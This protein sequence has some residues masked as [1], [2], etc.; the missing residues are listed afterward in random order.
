MSAEKNKYL[1]SIIIPVFNTAEYLD[2]CLRSVLEQTDN[3][4]E[5]I[6]IDDGS[7]DS[8]GKI[9]SL[10]CKNNKKFKLITQSNSGLSSARN[11]GIDIS[12]GDFITFLDSDDYLGVNSI[13]ILRKNQIEYHSDIVSARFMII[14]EKGK[15]LEH[16]KNYIKDD[17]YLKNWGYLK[18]WQQV[19]GVFA[20]SIV[21]ARLIRKSLLLDYNIKFPITKLPHED[22]CFTYKVL[23]KSSKNSQI[24]NAI[25][26][27]R[28]RSNS[29]SK[30]ISP[31][32]LIATLYQLQ[33]AKIFLGT[34]CEC[35][36]QSLLIRRTFIT[37]INYFHTMKTSESSSFQFFYTYLNLHRFELNNFLYIAKKHA[38]IKA[39]IIEDLEGI[40]CEGNNYFEKEFK[41]IK[42]SIVIPIYNCEKFLDATLKSIKNQSLRDFECIMVDDLS[43]DS[44]IT[45][46][47]KYA[48]LDSRFKIVKHKVNSG[49]AASRNSGTRIAKGKYICFLD[50]DDLM[51]VDGLKI[52]CV[53]LEKTKDESV[54]GCYCGSITIQE[55]EK[56]VPKG[57][58]RPQLGNIDFIS[59]RGRCLFNAN[60]P[61]F[62][63]N[64]FIRMGGFNESLTQAEDYEL[65][66]RFL[67]NGYKVI[68]V[69]FDGV[70]YRARRNS[71]IRKGSLVHLHT[72]IELQKEYYLP[73]SKARKYSA[74]LFY[75]N[76]P[77][78]TYQCQKDLISRILP[79]VGMALASGN[80]I[81]E[82]S[83]EIAQS[84]PSVYLLELKNEKIYELL[85][86]GLRRFHV[87]E[88]APFFNRFKNDLNNL[89]IE[90]RTKSLIIMK[91][92]NNSDISNESSV[93]ES[94]F[95]FPV[96]QKKV[97]IVFFPHKDYHIWTIHL[98]LESL[99]EQGL[100][101][102]VVDN[103]THYRD[104]GNRAKAKELNIELLR[105]SNFILGDYE[106]KLLVAFNDWDPIVKSIFYSA[107]SAGVGTASIVE[108]IQDYHDVDTK[109][110]RHPYLSSELVILPGEFDRKYFNNK[111][112]N[113]VVGGVPRILDLINKGDVKKD[114]VI[115][116]KKIA[117]INTNF[118]YGVLVDKRDSWLRKSV[119]SALHCGYKV[120]ISRH[121]ADLGKTYQKFVSDKNF[122][123]LLE[124]S[125]VVIQ[126]FAS[127]ILEAVARNKKTIYFNPHNEKIDKFKDPLGAYWIANSDTE[128]SNILKKLDS[129]AFNKENA[130]KF[131]SIHCNTNCI[132]ISG[133]IASQLASS[134]NKKDRAAINFL[135]FKQNLRTIDLASNSFTDISILAKNLPGIYGGKGLDLK[136]IN[137]KFSLLQELINPTI[138]R[139]I[140]PN[141]TIE[142]LEK[143]AL[144][145]MHKNFSTGDISLSKANE[146][147]R[148]KSWINALGMY[149]Y[150]YDINP[151]KVYSDNIKYVVNKIKKKS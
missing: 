6:I 14:S 125:D 146:Q 33:D 57:V 130:S 93:G 106:P 122:Y 56:K 81:S 1:I 144:V 13:E 134:V 76:N 65:W 78:Y 103:T 143:E 87:G 34:D 101:F 21:C 74:S 42:A 124:I 31:K 149:V 12:K 55:N 119:E 123:E 40:L 131:L 80:K 8:S 135:K 24:K 47:K 22:W 28:K 45:I 17:F 4:Y 86:S 37:I 108:G 67:R 128:L 147:I 105:Y 61:M 19:L 68:A 92:D 75:Y 10:Y 142:I 110:I 145:I 5:V 99:K 50:A 109:R 60:Q 32:K 9:A 126:R 11:K 3:N 29:L 89:I 111:R 26:F 114:T 79:F 141:K 88:S 116:E 91:L 150:L 77:G 136:A 38:T 115:G 72:S 20:S 73:A 15:V 85:M 59:A 52:R 2:E 129:L 95:N 23:N 39:D 107:H 53:A 43:T 48:Q 62:K 127:G 36:S 84:I 49:L 54:I 51:L 58:A 30:T 118:S 112:Q 16:Q 64:L 25:Y 66:N 132:N 133:L 35:L 100:K 63:T 41:Y 138:S 69:K 94:I 46:I 82:L 151:L 137:E 139:S 102:V 7:T 104:E 148:A 18:G 96:E 98:L 90:A 120:L 70:T 27:Y 97:D 121:P 113:I 71:M 140:P 83:D 117:L 44:S